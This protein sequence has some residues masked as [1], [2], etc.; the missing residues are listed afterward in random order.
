MTMSKL[1]YWQ[2]L[3][4]VSI[5]RLSHKTMRKEN[6]CLN[7]NVSLYLLQVCFYL[8]AVMVAV[9]LMSV[10]MLVK[11]QQAKQQQRVEADQR[12]VS[13]Y[14]CGAQVLKNHSITNTLLNSK[15]SIQKLT[16]QLVTLTLEKLMPQQ[17]SFKT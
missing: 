2:S 16:S 5:F 17:T 7:K 9:A 10:V 8:P 15:R 3:T 1:K 13:V 6:L 11:E 12:S 4:I 14:Q